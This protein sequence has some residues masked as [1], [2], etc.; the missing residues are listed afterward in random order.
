MERRA[1]AAALLCCVVPTEIFRSVLIVLHHLR[2][3]CAVPE[4]VLGSYFDRAGSSDVDRV[5]G[6]GGSHAI[7]FI[8]STLVE[9]VTLSVLPLFVYRELW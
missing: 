3:C 2:T 6:V 8:F 9:P 4:S 1:T 5:F 7:K